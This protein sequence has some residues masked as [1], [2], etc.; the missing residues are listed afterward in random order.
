M[1]SKRQLQIA[2]LVKRNMGM[3][4]QQ[5]GTYLYGT[6]ALVTVTEV[7]IS[8]DLGL[9]KIYLSVYNVEDKQTVL[10]QMEEQLVRIRQGLA[11]RVKR[12]MRRVPE[13]ALY[14]D[15]TLDEMYRLNN[16]FD[17]LNDQDQMGS[18]QQ[19]EE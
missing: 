16:L 14:L 18:S 19:E 11:N 10:L 8:P 13:I 12:Q 9:A 15:E 2:E 1:E 7:K 3:Y 6:E 5:E 17:R 4:L